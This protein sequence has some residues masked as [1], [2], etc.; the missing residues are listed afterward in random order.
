V[1][2]EAGS[3]AR[4]RAELSSAAGLFRSMDMA[5]WL[6]RAEDELTKAPVG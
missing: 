3:A 1:H 5:L 4:A 2:R 6:A